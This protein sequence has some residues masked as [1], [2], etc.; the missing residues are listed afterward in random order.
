MIGVMLG[1]G[2]YR[3]T[4]RLSAARAQRM[5]GLEFVVIEHPPR[6]FPPE[7]FPG[8]AKLSL[9]DLVAADHI[10]YLD[11]DA[12]VLREWRPAALADRA[13]FICVRDQFIEL[14]PDYDA[15]IPRSTYFN[16]G[17]FIVN[18]RAH[19]PVFDLA[20]KLWRDNARPL[21]I[22]DQS[23]LNYAVH[24]LGTPTHFLSDEYNYLRA[25]IDGRAADEGVVVA[26]YTPSGIAHAHRKLLDLLR[27]R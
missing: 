19:R 9:F 23:A 27:H 10:C 1:L 13:E 16:S 26:H 24:T 15:D 20:R 25:H 22:E 11:A 5:T 3:D 12:V 4:A 8:Y 2:A 7:A 21:P 18:R 17:M 6:N 14:Y